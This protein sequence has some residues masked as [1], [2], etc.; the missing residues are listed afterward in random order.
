MTDGYEPSTEVASTNQLV[1]LGCWAHARRYVIEAEENLPKAQR[2][3]D[4][5]VSE[6]FR[7]IGRLFAIEARCEDMTPDLRLQQRQRA[8][9]A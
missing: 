7:L 9:R 8:A 3:G 6:F 2:G 4:H 1:H 5:P